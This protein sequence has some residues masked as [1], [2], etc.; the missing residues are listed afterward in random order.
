MKLL[1]AVSG[2][3][4]SE[5]GCNGTQLILAANVLLPSPPKKGARGDKATQ[6]CCVVSEMK[7]ASG[8]EV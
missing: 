1:V 3:A 5:S 6:L 2:E 8:A 7:T 4:A